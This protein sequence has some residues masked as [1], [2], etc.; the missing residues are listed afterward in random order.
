MGLWA[1]AAGD[2]GLGLPLL[3]GAR[4][5]EACT[6]RVAERLD[7]RKHGDYRALGANTAQRH[8]RQILLF[9]R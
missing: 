5:E 9:T 1:G 3:I 8:Q 2:L 6:V 7:L 4:G